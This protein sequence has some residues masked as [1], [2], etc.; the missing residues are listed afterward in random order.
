MEAT[1]WK[2]DA[3]FGGTEE[4]KSKLVKQVMASRLPGLFLSC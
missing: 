1:T 3:M 4:F 2:V